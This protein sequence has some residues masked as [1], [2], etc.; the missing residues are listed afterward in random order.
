M[1]GPSLGERKELTGALDATL[2]FS[3]VPGGISAYLI[4]ALLRFFKP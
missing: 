3:G 1:L 4:I 2:L